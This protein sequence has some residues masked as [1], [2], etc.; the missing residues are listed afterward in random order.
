MTKMGM[1]LYRKISISFP[2]KSL[3]SLAIIIFSEQN[4]QEITHQSNVY[5]DFWEHTGDQLLLFS[6]R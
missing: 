4:E 2:A 1:K 3:E 5:V 6:L